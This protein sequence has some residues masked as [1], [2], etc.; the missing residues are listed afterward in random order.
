MLIYLL[1]GIAAGVAS[2]LYLAYNYH[3]L[4]LNGAI[5]AAIFASGLVAMYFTKKLTAKSAG[6]YLAG[7]LPVHLTI[8]FVIIGDLAQLIGVSHALLNFLSLP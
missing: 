4:L 2:A 3:P 5:H 8:H 7:A 1:I 6:W